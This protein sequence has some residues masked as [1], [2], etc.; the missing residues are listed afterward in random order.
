VLGAR[1]S[2]GGSVWSWAQCIISAGIFRFMRLHLC[3]TDTV[4]RSHRKLRDL[5]NS[6]LFGEASRVSC[7]LPNRLV[8]MG[9]RSW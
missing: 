3:R 2:H 5:F 1:L 7:A 4:M 6:D 8:G 9:Y